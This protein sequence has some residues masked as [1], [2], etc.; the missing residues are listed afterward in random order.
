[1]WVPVVYLCNVLVL[2]NFLFE[3][4]PALTTNSIDQGYLQNLSTSVDVPF[5]MDMEKGQVELMIS[6]WCYKF[7]NGLR[8]VL[9]IEGSSVKFVLG[10]SAAPSQ[11]FDLW[12]LIKGS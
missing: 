9:D 12:F 8:N 2:T 7:L 5:V 1:M 3:F 11:I 10:F 6:Q 4:L